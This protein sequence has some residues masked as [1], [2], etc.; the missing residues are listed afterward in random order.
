MKTI[1]PNYGQELIPVLW[2]TAI[3]IVV[4][5]SSIIFLRITG[6]GHSTIIIVMGSLAL[7]LAMTIAMSIWSSRVGKIIMRDKMIGELKLNGNET[8]LDIG[9]GRG[10]LTVGIA[11]KLSTGKV[12]GLD[13]WKGT[14]EYSY[15]REMAENN[16]LYEGIGNRVEIVDGDAMKLPFKEGYFNLVTSSLVMHHVPD[17]SQA[18]REMW[19]VL[20]PDGTI[21]I[22]DMPTAEFRKQITNSGFEIIS[23]KPLVR[24]F[25]IRVNL[26]IAKKR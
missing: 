19:R 5:L 20:K 12:F 25:F 14:F 18:F 23:I 2:I 4:L 26:I 11:K 16:I 15:T 8:I 22:A 3:L 13:H 17:T 24:L 7:F 1:K 21:A 10:L 9:C 6:S